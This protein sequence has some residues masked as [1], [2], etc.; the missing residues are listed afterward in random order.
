[1]QINE[2]FLQYIW[3]FKKLPLFNL[4]TVDG[5]KVMIVQSGIWNND[6]GPDFINAKLYIGK[7][8]WSGNV[9]I[10]IESSDWYRHGHHKDPMYDSV[11]LHIVLLQD[12]K[13]FRQNGTEIP[14]IE[15]HESVVREHFIH[16]NKMFGG[17]QA[18][19]CSRHFAKI[20]DLVF[21]N[22]LERSAIARVIEKSEYILDY[23]EKTHGDWNQTTYFL[24]LRSFGF[25]INA[26]PFEIL[27]YAL[28]YK[29]LRK[30]LSN[31]VE[32]ESLM[33]GQAGFLQQDFGDYYYRLL[34]SNYDHLRRKYTLYPM[35]IAKWKFLR[36]RPSNFPTVRIAQLAGFLHGKSH[37]FDFMMNE[38][39][40]SEWADV[41][42]EI[43][44][45][46]FWNNHYHFNKHCEE[47]LS[48]MGKKSVYIILIN[49]IVP[50]FYAYGTY[51]GNN[52]LKFKAISILEQIPLE[53]NVV[54]R[55]FTPL[56]FKF[57]N[58]LQTQGAIQ[59]YQKLCAQ[60][61]CLQCKV[62][63]KL[64]GLNS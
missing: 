28:P 58:A 3:Q 45:P 30:H 11:V 37:L 32:L 13:V 24:L 54:I 56:N 63:V 44:M 38:R 33:F 46:D 22:Q 29:V 27:S 1:M 18:I 21:Q 39:T 60:K 2:H 7:T 23:L 42:S 64:M 36:L 6:A 16:Y 26:V 43:K 59:L 50:L 12:Q 48:A 52:E 17:K 19:A 10:H 41:F 51:I 61:R 40:I 55:Q 34:Q 31:G 5:E 20:E 4:F 57:S 53:S 8:L 9:E 47:K 62:G 49:V 35:Q 14:A 25:H 15:I